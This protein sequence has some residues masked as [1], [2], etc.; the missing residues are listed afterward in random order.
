MLHGLS[1]LGSP[2]CLSSMGRNSAAKLHFG[3][4]W[5]HGTEHF[6]FSFPCLFGARK[7]RDAVQ[8]IFPCVRPELAA[9]GPFLRP[10]LY[11]LGGC[12]CWLCG[13]LPPAFTA[14]FYGSGAYSFWSARTWAAFG[15][16]GSRV[17][18]K[19][20]AA[21]CLLSPHCG[22]FGFRLRGRARNNHIDDGLPPTSSMAFAMAL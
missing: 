2:S 17:R 10:P 14:L 22:P 7:S 20:R 3:Q 9:L 13:G 5:L 19:Q 12:R 15:C 1:R 6:G 4:G 21:G 8:R 11:R 18:P 16:C